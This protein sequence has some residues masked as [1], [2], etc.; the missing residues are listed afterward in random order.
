LYWLPGIFADNISLDFVAL[1]YTILHETHLNMSVIQVIG[2]K[3]NGESFE[4]VEDCLT[5]ESPLQIYLN[6]EPFTVTMTTPGHEVELTRGLLFTEDIASLD[7]SPSISYE[8]NENGEISAVHCDVKN[9]KPNKSSRTLISASSCGLCG[10]TALEELEPSGISLKPSSSLDINLLPSMFR[11]MQAEQENFKKSGG[12]HA[13]AAFD[14]D[15]NLLNCFEDIG[16]HNAVDKVIGDLILTNRF[17]QAR[18]LLVSGRISYEI[19][20]KAAKA[21]IAYL[22]AVSAPSSLSVS[23]AEKM[24]MTLIAFCRDNRATVY[25]NAGNI[26]EGQYALS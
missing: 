22:V 10:K 13:A 14:I 2:Q 21:S 20:S 11:Q 26:K 12:C 1:F 9:I 4:Q 16:R 19:V 7:D 17:N 25:S 23:M 3:F 15:G 5:V 24:G 18:C 6:G 8:Q